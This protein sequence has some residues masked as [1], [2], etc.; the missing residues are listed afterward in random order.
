VRGQRDAVPASPFTSPSFTKTTFTPHCQQ[1][2]IHGVRPS[3]SRPPLPP[4]WRPSPVT[5]KPNQPT[6]LAPMPFPVP[7][8]RPR[9]DCPAH[10][11]AASPRTRSS[12]NGR[13]PIRHRS[14]PPRQRKPRTV[15]ASSRTSSRLLAPRGRSPACSSVPPGVHSVR[16]QQHSLAR[17][18]RTAVDYARRLSSAVVVHPGSTTARVRGVLGCGGG[19][20][21]A[22]V[23]VGGSRSVRCRGTPPA[24]AIGKSLTRGRSLRPWS[25]G[26]RS[27]PASIVERR[28]VAANQPTSAAAGISASRRYFDGVGSGPQDVALRNYRFDAVAARSRV[29]LTPAMPSE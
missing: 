27:P 20:A 6:P 23:G 9:I 26:T 18:P 19:C 11:P 10:R 17:L 5:L 14:S 16:P 22:R 7:H 29:L 28:R 25:G 3:C 21:G 13:A 24:V 8:P 15:A 2:V 4:S 1:P 12:R